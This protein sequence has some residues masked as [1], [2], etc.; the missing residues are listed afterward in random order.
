MKNI[1]YIEDNPDFLNLVTNT[2]PS[3]YFCQPFPDADKALMAYR[4]GIRPE[5]IITD[6]RIPRKSGL[7]FIKEIRSIGYINP[8]I[9]ATGHIDRG[10]VVEAMR[11][12]VFEILDKPFTLD[13]LH[14]AVKRGSEIVESRELQYLKMRK[15]T[16]LITCLEQVASVIG[17][18]E[19]DPRLVSLIEN[20]KE[21]IQSLERREA[22]LNG[23]K[24]S[25]AN[26]SDR[27]L[28]ELVE[29]LLKIG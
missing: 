16:N 14:N 10:D 4:A 20:Y 28:D 7:Q 17:P 18:K 22:I 11:M 6:I 15:M 8:I 12:G 24:E 9:I 26:G 21:E 25:V 3:G 2:L 29:M 27:D 5:L 13:S 19:R 1:F 23:S